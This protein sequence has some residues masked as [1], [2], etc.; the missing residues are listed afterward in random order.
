ME[1]IN[2]KLQELNKKHKEID[3]V[4]MK[5]C[6][7]ILKTPVIL[8]PEKPVLIPIPEIWY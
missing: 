6:E 4:E 3:L 8:K 1:D 5:R 2:R 7:A